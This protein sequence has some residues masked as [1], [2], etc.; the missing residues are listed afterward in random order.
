VADK[1]ILQR[2]AKTD[3]VNLE[4]AAYVVLAAIAAAWMA[5][6]CWGLARIERPA[7]SYD[8]DRERFEGHLHRLHGPVDARPLVGG[9]ARVP[10]APPL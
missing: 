8:R 7:S 2:E 10:G 9:G 3:N 1:R 6:I 4:R 5:V